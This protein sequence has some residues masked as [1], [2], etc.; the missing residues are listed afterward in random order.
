MTGQ[1]LQAYEDGCE[2]FEGLR[3]AA[4]AHTLQ[5][6]GGAGLNIHHV[7]GRVKKRA[8]L[9]DKLRRKPGRYGALSDVTDLVAV[10]VI[11]Y[12]ESDVSVVSRLLEEHHAIDW[13][14]SIDKSK[15]HDPDRF[16]YMGVHYVVQV[17]P[18]S[19]DL[20]AF[21]GLKFEVQIRSILQHAWAEIEHDLGYKN[22]EAIP[23]EVQRRFYRLAGLLEMADEEFMTL[24]R[25]SQQYTATLPARVQDAPDAVFIDAPSMRH[26]L[27]VPPVR[28]LDQQVAGALNVL[29]LTDWPDPE[30]PQRLASLLHYV[31]VHSV[32]ALQKELR[33]HEAE[34]VR[35]ASLLLPRLR[36]AWTPAGGARPGTSV[37][38]YALLRACANPLLDPHEIVSMLDMRGVLSGDQLVA[39]VRE[40]YTQ[41]TSGAGPAGGLTV[42]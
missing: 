36:E 32:G 1:L 34:V 26:L 17:T 15:M 30:R 5:L 38:H 4:V 42:A 12:F 7:T 11:T 21:A 6:I 39:A 40:A 28:D 14:N 8:S 22:R 13:E 37:V 29:L 16:G 20:A 24:H 33:R 23:R 25:L 3:D 2:T 18:D 10:R 31:G 35:F 19:P 41:A 9:E 27:D